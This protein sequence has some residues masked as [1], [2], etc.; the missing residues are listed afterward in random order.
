[1][2]GDIEQKL[3]KM[4]HWIEDKDQG[5]KTIIREDF[6][7]KTREEGKGV[8]EE[9]KDGEKEAEEEIEGRL[10]IIVGVVRENEKGKYTFTGG[11]GNTVIDYVIG[12]IGVKD[13]I[14]KMTVEDRVDLDHHP[15][16]KLKG[17]VRG[18]RIKDVNRK[19]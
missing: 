10:F 5:V 13:R 7:A 15:I 12:N 3:Q 17:E 8:V 1:M 14:K 19:C 18:K 4:G 2:N 6:N 11:R 16:Y 9:K